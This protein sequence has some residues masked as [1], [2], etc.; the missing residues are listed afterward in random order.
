M[1]LSLHVKM[2]ERSK[3]AHHPSAFSLVL[4]QLQ[5]FS[6]RRRSPW[7]Q[8]PSTP[9]SLLIPHGQEAGLELILR[10]NLGQGDSDDLRECGLI[11][12]KE[13]YAAALLILTPLVG[14]GH[15]PQCHQPQG[16]KSSVSKESSYINKIH[17]KEKD[18]KT[19]FNVKLCM[20]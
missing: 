19:F 12:R 14:S 20:F 1:F 11:R 17:R 15:H 2:T 10:P 5:G 7:G 4:P 6:W 13:C 8:A 18:V 16:H 3:I 9:S